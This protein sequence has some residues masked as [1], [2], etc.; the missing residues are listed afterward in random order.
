MGSARDLAGIEEWVGSKELHQ[1]G[2]HFAAAR[3]RE[4]LRQAHRRAILG[5]E[6]RHQL[7]VPERSYMGKGKMGGVEVEKTLGGDRQASGTGVEKGE[8]SFEEADRR[9]LRNLFSGFEGEEVRSPTKSAPA[10]NISVTSSSGDLPKPQRRV[11]G[12]MS[13]SRGRQLIGRGRKGG[14]TWGK[15]KRKRKGTAP[16]S[17][18]AGKG[19]PGERS[20][21]SWRGGL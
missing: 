18:D 5:A 13:R 9:G 4:E 3:G 2:D 12:K 7:G 8:T 1:K 19:P 15:E 16:S 20:V 11:Q 21:L 14:K 10:S 6:T 17:S